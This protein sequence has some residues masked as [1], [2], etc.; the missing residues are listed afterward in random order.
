LSARLAATAINCPSIPADKTAA[1]QI[2]RALRA[3]KITVETGTR[4]G[5]PHRQYL[6]A[7]IAEMRELPLVAI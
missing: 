4:D 1:G 3:I 5:F 2:M 6:R 7:E